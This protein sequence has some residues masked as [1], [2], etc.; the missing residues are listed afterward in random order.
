MRMV[1]VHRAHRII[2][3]AIL[4]GPFSHARRPR[5]HVPEPYV[6]ALWPSRGLRLRGASRRRDG[7]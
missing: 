4:R 2:T 3:Y 7:F 6:N 1:T 5:P